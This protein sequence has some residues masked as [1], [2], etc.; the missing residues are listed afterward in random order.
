MQYIIIQNNTKYSVCNN[1]KLIITLNERFEEKKKLQLKVINFIKK[2]FIKYVCGDFLFKFGCND[3]N[4][5]NNNFFD[6]DID[7]CNINFF[8]GYYFV[9][10]KNNTMKGYAECW[11][12][13]CIN[14][15]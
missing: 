4:N 1:F 11:E 12:M 14:C 10:N 9:T 15:Y 5:N 6:V 2:T 13:S 3:S 8:D 7:E